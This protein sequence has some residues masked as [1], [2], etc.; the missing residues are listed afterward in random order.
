MEKFGHQ[1]RTDCDTFA[2]HNYCH[3]GQLKDSRNWGKNSHDNNSTSVNEA[4]RKPT[5]VTHQCQSQINKRQKVCWLEITSVNQSNQT[6][7]VGSARTREEKRRR[8]GQHCFFF[9]FQ[10]YIPSVRGSIV[11]NLNESTVM[12]TH[13]YSIRIHTPAAMTMK[14]T[15]AWSHLPPAVWKKKNNLLPCLKNSCTIKLLSVRN[16]TS[17]TY[18]LKPQTALVA[19]FMALCGNFSLGTKKKKHA[20]IFSTVFIPN[21]PQS[22]PTCLYL[23][24]CLFVI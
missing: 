2:K 13:T 18:S 17:T 19:S 1:T 23:S 22:S 20:N 15:N 24:N 8:V 10:M 21:Y 7:L 14:K 11:L 3:P 9:Y 16:L 12:H 5:A 4:G 6:G